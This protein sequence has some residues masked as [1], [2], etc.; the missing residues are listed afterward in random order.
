MY[1]GY[2]VACLLFC[3]GLI[4]KCT[5]TDNRPIGTFVMKP[6][7]NDEITFTI[8]EDGQVKFEQY[9]RID[10][11]HISNY[12]D[13]Y[14]MNFKYGPFVRYTNSGETYLYLKNGYIYIDVEDFI[15]E[16]PTRRYEFK[17]K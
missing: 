10:Y 5:D 7:S 16:H 6:G 4:L 2:L 13:G 3:L 8:N 11:G 15:S 17:E 12:R 1:K 9:E 14:S